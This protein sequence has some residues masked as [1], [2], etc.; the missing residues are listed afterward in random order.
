MFEN[1]DIKNNV[2]IITRE[3]GD[4]DCLHESTWNEE[5]KE[6][7]RQFREMYPDGRPL[8]E[9]EPQV[10]IPTSEERITLLENTLT[11]LTQSMV[12][13]GMLTETQVSAI[14]ATSQVV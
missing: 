7:V 13:N 6:I 5:E 12:M 8:P 11:A 4:T 2:L 9:V 14:L 1:I 10:P 3:N